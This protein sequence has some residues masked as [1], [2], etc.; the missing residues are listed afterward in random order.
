MERIRVQAEV[1]VSIAEALFRY[2]GVAAADATT[3]ARVQIEADLRGMHSH[4]MRAV[5]MYLERIR[6]GVIN[7]RPTI[8]V[9]DQG[10]AAIVHGDDGPGQVVAVRAM[11]ECID[12]ARRFR[13]GVT[14]VHRSNHFGAAGYY[15][16]MAVANDLIGFATTNGNLVLAP[17]GGITPTVGNNP[18]AVG[19]PA[20]VGTDRIKH[21]AVLGSIERNGLVGL[22]SGVVDAL[23]K[24]L[25]IRARATPCVCRKAPAH[26]AASLPRSCPG[27]CGP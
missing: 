19:V 1:L 7:P 26:A 27:E 11:E 8:E 15:A 24:I 18:I 23:T 4:G 17:W 14:L 16:G 22:D 6:R 3:I 13:V 12:R 25:G 20:G 9:Q 21:E 2:E 5:P 10:V